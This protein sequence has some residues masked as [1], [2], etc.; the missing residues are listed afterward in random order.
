MDVL[1]VSEEREGILLLNKPTGITSFALVGRLRKLLNV[2]K[3]G[4]A[5]TLDPFA[6][7]LMVMLVGRNFT[8]QSDSLLTQDKEY[9][10]QAKLGITTDSFDCDGATT[11]ESDH[12]PSLAEVEAAIA[13]FQGSIEQIPPMFSAKKVGGRKLC[14]LARKG[15]TVE[16]APVTV[17]V[18]ID[19]LSYEYPSLMFR[20]R[21]SKGTYIRALAH[22]IGQ[23]LGCGAHL[24]HLHRTRSGQFDL[25]DAL[26]ADA[27]VLDEVLEALAAVPAGAPF[28]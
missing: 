7:G 18:S 19:L 14:D 28:S 15:Q 20:A 6:T 22:D 17:Q 26:D 9:V 8:R 10:A 16:R 23:L 27:L 4:H 12:Q 1:P 11:G 21:C 3:I 24:T 5:G 25:K 2:R 13:K